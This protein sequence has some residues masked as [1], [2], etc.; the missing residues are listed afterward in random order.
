MGGGGIGWVREAS[1]RGAGFGEAEATADARAARSR[2]EYQSRRSFIVSPQVRRKCDEDARFAREDGRKLTNGFGADQGIPLRSAPSAVP[3]AEV[4]DT[5]SLRNCL[6]G[7]ATPARLVGEAGFEPATSRTRTVRAGQVALLP[8][9][10][11]IVLRSRHPANTRSRNP[12]MN[13][14]SRRPAASA[15]MRSPWCVSAPGCVPLPASRAR[16]ACR[17]RRASRR[18]GAAPPPVAAGHPRYPRSSPGPHPAA[19]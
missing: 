4:T 15:R 11:P 8:D 17:A 1:L 6:P 12:A 19:P 9:A 5:A 13:R 3:P 7:P 10:L 14:R 18:L 2:Y 16:P